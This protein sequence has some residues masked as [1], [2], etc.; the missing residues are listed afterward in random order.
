M[1]GRWWV[2]L[3]WLAA[4]GGDDARDGDASGEDAV[5]DVDVDVSSDVGKDASD[6]HADSDASHG[7]DASDASHVGEVSDASDASDVSDTTSA[8]RYVVAQEIG[9]TVLAG[10]RGS[11]RIAPIVGHAKR[12]R[13]G[14]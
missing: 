8:P 10:S 5:Q 2:V 13:W 1:S 6:A 7:S 12:L 3:A 4:C 11:L 14:R 9:V